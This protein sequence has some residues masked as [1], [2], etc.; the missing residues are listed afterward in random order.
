MGQANGGTIFLDEIGELPM[1]LQKSMLRV[2]QEHRYRPVGSQSEIA[3][4]FR[5]VAATN[6]DLE[7][8]VQKGEFREDLLYRLKAYHIKL[9]NLQERREDI[10]TIAMHFLDRPL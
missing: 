5:L 1:M 3:S 6:R 4:D 9:P 8:C 7:D 10:K 2:L